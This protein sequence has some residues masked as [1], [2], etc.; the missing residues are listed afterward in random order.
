MEGPSCLSS[1]QEGQLVMLEVRR[2]DPEL[3]FLAGELKQ[4]A[5]DCSVGASSGWGSLEEGYLLAQW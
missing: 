3:T 2:L 4:F 5:Y 1:V